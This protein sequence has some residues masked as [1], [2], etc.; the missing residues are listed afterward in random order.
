M[1][2]AQRFCRYFCALALH[3]VVRIIDFVENAQMSLPN[4]A[5]RQDTEGRTCLHI[6][7]DHAMAD[8]ARW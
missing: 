7:A 1:N 3:T 2:S 6:A 8:L 5:E 4:F